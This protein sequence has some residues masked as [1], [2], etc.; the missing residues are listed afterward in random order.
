MY[1]VLF[2]FYTHTQQKIRVDEYLFL[3]L[4][5]ATTSFTLRNESSPNVFR[6]RRGN[7]FVEQ[8]WNFSQI[9]KSLNANCDIQTFWNISMIVPV[10]DLY[11]IIKFSFAI[12]N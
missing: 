6:V 7:L 4:S 5:P 12:I 9:L 1:F 2:S 3:L 11:V 8:F 10:A